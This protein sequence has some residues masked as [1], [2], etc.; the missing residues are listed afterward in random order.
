METAG[1][2]HHTHHEDTWSSIR[3]PQRLL[4]CEDYLINRKV[5]RWDVVGLLAGRRTG[6]RAGKDAELVGTGPA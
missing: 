2:E 1:G 5:K 4:H 6:D 3:R